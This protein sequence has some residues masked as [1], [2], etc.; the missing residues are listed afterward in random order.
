MCGYVNIV[1][2][3][4]DTMNVLWFVIHRCIHVHIPMVVVNTSIT[5][6]SLGWL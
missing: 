6:N 4:L 5:F 3:L 2:E 1:P